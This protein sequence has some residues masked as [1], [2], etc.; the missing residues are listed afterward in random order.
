MS[1]NWEHELKKYLAKKL[2]VDINSLAFVELDPPKYELSEMTVR[3]LGQLYA[4]LITK[5]DYEQAD[6]VKKLLA[7][8][9]CVVN[10][11]I[12]DDEITGSIEVNSK[13]KNKNNQVQVFMKLLSNGTWCIDFE[14]ENF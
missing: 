14:K 3:G 5:E 12:N 10:F 7:E 4:F 8:K 2:N 1:N 9:K 11:K 6:V 13:P